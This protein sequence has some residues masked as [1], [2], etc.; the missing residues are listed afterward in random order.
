MESQTLKALIGMSARFVLFLIFLLSTP[1]ALAA[2]GVLEI[3]AA[4]AVNSGCFAGDAAG[5]P[6]TIDS[7]AGSHGFRLTSDLV[8]SSSNT[9]AIQVLENDV[10]IDLSGFGILGAACVGSTTDCTPPSIGSPG[11]RGIDAVGVRG[12]SVQNGTISGMGREG[13]V[14]SSQARISGV[15]VRWNRLTGINTFDGSLIMDSIAYQNRSNGFSPGFGS[16]IIR[17]TATEN[18]ATGIFVLAEGL[19]ADCTVRLNN[20]D[21]IRAGARSTVRNNTVTQTG[22]GSLFDDGID[23]ADGATIIGNTVEGSSGVGIRVGGGAMVRDNAVSNSVGAGILVSN[24]GSSIFDNTIRL[25]GGDGVDASDGGYSYIRGNLAVE[26]ALFGLNLSDPA[27]AD[28]IYRDNVV[29]DNAGGTVSGGNERGGNS[30]RANVG[31]IT[32]CP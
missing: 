17:C 18:I 4:C 28:A 30:C 25:S 9:T 1:A 5:Y 15:T 20:G 10:S 24:P 27:I 21:G 26:N 3:N 8:I 2:D 11:G 32:N 14:G 6:V 22:D 19:V 31:A 7:T 16:T 23:A 29:Y 12:L 13:I